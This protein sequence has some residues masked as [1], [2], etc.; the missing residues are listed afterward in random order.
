MFLFVLVMAVVA[1]EGPVADRRM[2]QNVV[3]Q[4]QRVA[5]DGVAEMKADA[6]AFQLPA[7]EIGRGSDS[8]YCTVY[9]RIG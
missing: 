7:G 1:L 2:R 8:R 4:H 6:V 5:A 9:S 3:G